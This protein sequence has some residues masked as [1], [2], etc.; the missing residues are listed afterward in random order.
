MRRISDDTRSN[1]VTLLQQGLSTRQVAERCGVSKSTVQNIRKRHLPTITQLRGGRVSK[2][3]SQNKRFCIRTITSEKLET[4][5]A[6][7]KKLRNDLNVEASERAVRRCLQEAGLAAMEKEN[8]SKLSTKNIKAR[9]EFAKRHKD[10]TVADWKH[11]IW[12]D[13][14]KI[15]RFCSDGRSWCWARDGETRQP[16]QIKETVK[17]GGGSLMIWGCMMVQGPGFMCRL[18]GTM[19]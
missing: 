18:T 11:I 15:S 5:T 17:H 13:E 2:L 9:L 3:S 16:R 7:V 14:T 10:W 1:I 6:V 4:A 12:S 19:D 8:R